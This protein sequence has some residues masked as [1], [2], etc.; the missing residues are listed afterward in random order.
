MVLVSVFPEAQHWLTEYLWLAHLLSCPIQ[1]QA[2]CKSEL[3]PRLKASIPSLCLQGDHPSK[4]CSNVDFA[5]ARDYAESKK[6]RFQAHLASNQVP[7][8]IVWQHSVFPLKTP[9]CLLNTLTQVHKTHIEVDVHTFITVQIEHT[10]CK[11][12]VKH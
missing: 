12:Y 2:A 8:F 3:S 9:S 11:Y 5:V 4:I 6:D 10:Y 7:C 1:H